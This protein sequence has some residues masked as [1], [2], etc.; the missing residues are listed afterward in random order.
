MIKHYPHGTFCWVDL[1]TT[2]AQTAQSFYTGLF[3]WQTYDIAAGPGTYTMFTLDGAEVAA[4]SSMSAE[5]REQGIPPVWSNY[6]ATDDVDA[7]AGKVAELGGTVLVPPMDIMDAGRMSFIQDPQGAPLGLWQA[8][9]HIGARKVNETGCLLWNE[10]H[11]SDLD[12]AKKFYAALL[13]WDVQTGPSPTGMGDYT[14]FRVA[15]R[16]NGGILEMTEEW[17]DV[18]PHWAPY[19]LVASSND[20]AQ[21]C[22]ELGGSVPVEPF[23]MGGMGRMAVLTDPQGATF[24]IMQLSDAP[25]AVPEDWCR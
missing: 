3:D 25:E 5:M 16:E 2:D 15:G 19:F 14:L 9:N 6:V 8:G 17:G 10:L 7:V 1:A 24:S 21:A 11:T 20:K 13:G 23:D 22:K 12:A 4:V 18:P